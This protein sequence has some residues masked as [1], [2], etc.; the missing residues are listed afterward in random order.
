MTSVNLDACLSLFL[1]LFILIKLKVKV[2]SELYY[3][4]KSKQSLLKLAF[5]VTNTKCGYVNA[6]D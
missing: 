2:D 6:E 3:F 5:Q 1:N 4:R